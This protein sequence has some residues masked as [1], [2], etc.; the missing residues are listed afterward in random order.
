[1]KKKIIIMIKNI[2]KYFICYMK[3]QEAVQREFQVKYKSGGA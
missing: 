3:R 2:A 1:M